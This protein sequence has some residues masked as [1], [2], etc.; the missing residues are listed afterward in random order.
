MIIDWRAWTLGQWAL[1]AVVLLGPMVALYA[2][3]PSLGSPPVWLAGLV[4]VLACAWA[5]VPE[6]V[7]GAVVLLLAGWSWAASGEGVVPAG[8]LVAAAGMLAAHLA[9]LVVG[10]GPSRLP[11][12]PGVVRLWA[13]RGALVFV[14]AV[15]VWI[16]ARGVR[17][18]PDSSTVWVVGL[19][20]AVSVVVV[21]AAAVQ[22]TVPQGSEEE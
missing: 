21:A 19:A 7:A 9:A 2:R 4:F 10:Y 18:L 20:V 22:A 15:V 8:A 3:G 1:R 5:L 12:A 6:S 13:R 14:P 16:L 11:V 17:E